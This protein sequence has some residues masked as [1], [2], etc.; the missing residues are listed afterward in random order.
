ML[1][2][3]FSRTIACSA[4]SWARARWAGVSKS[5]VAACGSY[6]G[7]NSPSR[8]RTESC[9]RTARV[10]VLLRQQALGQ[11]A[12]N[13]GDDL[14]TV[15]AVV[16]EAV[17]AGDQRGGR[18]LLVGVEVVLRVDQVGGRAGVRA[19]QQVLVRPGAQLRVQV[20]REVVGAA[21]DQVV[22]GHHTGHRAGLDRLAEGAQV[23]LV[24]HA[25]A[26]RARCGGPVRLV[27]VGQ[28]V[29]E[30]RGRTPVRGV[31]AAQAAGVGGGDRRGE[32][33][34]LR[35]A[36]LVAAPQRVAQQV[37]RRRPD[38]EAD[39]VVV[40]AHRAD[41]LGHRLADAV[42]ELLVPGRAEADR[43]REDGRRA[44]PRHPVQ[45]LLAGTEGGD[46]ET[47]DGGCELV[48]ERHPFVE[49]EAR[50]QIVDA[51]R[52]R[53]LRIA[54]WRRRRRLCGH[55]GSLCDGASSHIRSASMLIRRGGGCQE[56]QAQ[57]LRFP[58]VMSSGIRGRSGRPGR[59]PHLGGILEPTLVHPQVF[60]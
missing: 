14:R 16:G 56:T 31:V 54:E 42:H 60:T 51:L 53:Q 49:G 8:K 4:A 30:D 23:V 41:L 32:P 52:D 19:D 44:H 17:H 26:D 46:A 24:Q 40:G 10:D 28:P 13:A 58:P 7:S 36:L 5:E 57:Q 43:L 55:V 15:R 50:Q 12:S 3:F 25:R 1:S 37:D 39:A 33:R 20:R 45:R 35:V 21:V 2:S 6:C 22:R 38:V 11:G 9:R 47:L 48:Q 34:V 29:L 18:R 59:A 27:V